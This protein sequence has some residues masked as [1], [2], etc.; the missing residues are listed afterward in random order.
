[1]S[2][3]A[4]C[5]SRPREPISGSPISL[6]GTLLS[7]LG[8]VVSGF[9]SDKERQSVKVCECFEYLHSGG[10]ARGDLEGTTSRTLPQCSQLPPGAYIEYS[11]HLF[12]AAAERRA[13][14]GGGAASGLL[15]TH[16]FGRRAA[17][18]LSP[19]P[20]GCGPGAGGA[21]PLGPRRGER[22][23]SVVGAQERVGARAEG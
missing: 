14:P 21:G 3:R 12:T 22:L 18:L 15:S 19:P 6:S 2:L 8:L 23:Y 1:V 7:G 17:R 16:L 10:K 11:R 9:C 5:V 4:L 13:A 20:Q